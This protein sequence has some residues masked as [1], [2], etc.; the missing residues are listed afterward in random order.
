MNVY[1]CFVF[2]N[3]FIAFIL[4][5]FHKSS[6]LGKNHKMLLKILRSFDFHNSVV[7][8]SATGFSEM[9]WWF[10][11]RFHILHGSFLMVSGFFCVVWTFGLMG[12][13]ISGTESLLD[14]TS[15]TIQSLFSFLFP[16]QE[17]LCQLY[18]VVTKE[19]GN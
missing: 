7:S 2:T 10:L 12:R 19:K 5:Y 15:F 18:C 8:L 4:K 16:F 3:I 1:S 17:V 6:A 14:V 13:D 11:S 9:P